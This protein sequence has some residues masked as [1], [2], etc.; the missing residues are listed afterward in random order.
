M[1][2]FTIDFSS[3]NEKQKLYDYLKTLK[4]KN[5]VKIEKYKKQRTTPQN[6]YYWGVVLKYISDETGF[7]VEEMHEVLKFKFLQKSKVTKG[8]QLE[9][10]IQSTSELT[11]EEFEEFL[12]K[13]RL[14]SINFLG[15][16]IPLPNEVII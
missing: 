4:G 6:S 12:D 15:L 1:A 3:Y 9:T 2:D 11:T 8:G 14:W 7:S 5:L 13:V 16:N 10:Y